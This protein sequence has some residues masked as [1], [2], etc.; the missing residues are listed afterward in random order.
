MSEQLT[1][2]ESYLLILLA[3]TLLKFLFMLRS[4]LSA[5]DFAY[6][7]FHSLVV[8]PGIPEICSESY[9][10]LTVTL[11]MVVIKTGKRKRNPL[12]LWQ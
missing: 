8:L 5:V 11:I 2:I 9:M 4:K 3:K 10:L 7:K 1:Y 6:K 12:L